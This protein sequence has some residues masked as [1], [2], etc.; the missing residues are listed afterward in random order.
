MSKN[1]DRTLRILHEVFELKRLHY[2]MWIKKDELTFDNLKLAQKRYESN[3]I[4]QIPKN[5]KTILD[6][7]CGTGVMTKNL[8]KLG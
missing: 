5:V 8:L 4:K 2:G 6:V 1:N 3:I 7:G